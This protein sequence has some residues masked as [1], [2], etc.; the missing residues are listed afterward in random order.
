MKKTIILILV[1]NFS[2]AFSQANGGQNFHNSAA[3][4]VNNL[5]GNVNHVPDSYR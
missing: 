5:T 2:F 3:P 4:F 1:L